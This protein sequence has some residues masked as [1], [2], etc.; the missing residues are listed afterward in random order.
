M[1]ASSALIATNTIAQGDTRS[2][3]L[4]WICEHG[5][6]D[7]SLPFKRVKWPGE[8]AVIVSVLHIAKGEFAAAKVLDGAIRGG[9]ITAFLFHRGG[10]AIPVRLAKPMPA[11]ASWEAMYLRYGIHLRRHRQTRRIASSSRRDAPPD[12]DRIRGTVKSSS[13]TSAVRRST[14][15]P[16][17]QHH[18]Y[19]INFGEYRSER[20]CRSSWPKMNSDQPSSIRRKGESF[21][22]CHPEPERAESGHG[23]RTAAIVVAV[24][25]TMESRKR[26]LSAA[27]VAGLD[28][29]ADATLQA[30]ELTLQPPIGASP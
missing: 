24:H 23:R 2:S 6:R 15:A 8:A 30:K 1:A 16:T 12:R 9:Q 26:P 25:P 7:L 4:R 14:P 3:G 29:G 5:G 10:H 21:N 28:R 17:M 18:R 19:V 20:E 22:V 11:G 27:T 13:P